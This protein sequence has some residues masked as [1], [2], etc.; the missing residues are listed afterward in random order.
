MLGFAF[1]A[2]GMAMPI[3]TNVA[4]LPRDPM[5]FIFSCGF[6][7]LGI[8]GLMQLSKLFC[9]G[10]AIV[11][12]RTSTEVILRDRRLVC[13]ERF[14]VFR[15]VRRCK[16]PVDQLRQLTIQLARLPSSQM[17]G[18]QLTTLLGDAR[19]LLTAQWNDKLQHRFTIGA[20]YPMDTLQRPGSRLAVLRTA[21]EHRSA[22]GFSESEPP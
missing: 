8:V 16:V 15:Y 6:A 21:S 17:T 2:S 11:L 3:A 4:I 1:L 10:L 20:A 18:N 12:N 14:F 9:L 13:H 7:C 22:G 5:F 19:G